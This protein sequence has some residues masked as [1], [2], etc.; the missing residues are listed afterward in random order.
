MPES[1]KVICP[2]CG[3]EM[4]HH[5]MKIDYGV[6]DFSLVDPVFGGALKEAYTCPECGHTELISSAPHQT[7]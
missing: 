6:D 2:H 4:N 7:M 5:A 3:A 1:N